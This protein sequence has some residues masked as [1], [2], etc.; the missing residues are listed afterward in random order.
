MLSMIGVVLVGRRKELDH[1]DVFFRSL[2]QCLSDK[3]LKIYDRQGEPGE[4]RG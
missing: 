1:S 2:G 3:I 4:S